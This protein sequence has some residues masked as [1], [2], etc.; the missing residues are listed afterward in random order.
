VI[1]F[2]K[3]HRL[4]H[5][6]AE[7]SAREWEPDEQRDLSLFRFGEERVNRF[8]PENIENDLSAAT[9][10]VSRKNPPPPSLHAHAKIVNF[11]FAFQFA[12]VLE[13]FAALQHVERDAVKL[14]EIE[15]L[16][17]QP[18]ERRLGVLA[19]AGARKILGQPGGSKR[20]SLVRHKFF[21]ARG[22]LAQKFPISVSLRPI[23]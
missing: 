11:S 3:R 4:R 13:D 9:P 19:H 17:A 21:H 23:P 16:D 5:L 20:P 2:G 7:E 14:R 18:L 15:R 8:L 10:S 22:R 1:V 6:A 12:H